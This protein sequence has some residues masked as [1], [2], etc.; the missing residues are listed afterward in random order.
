MDGDLRDPVTLRMMR[1]I[2]RRIQ[3]CGVS[4]SQSIASI[5]AE[6]NE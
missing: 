5:I 2:E 1:E 6:M 4:K 3:W